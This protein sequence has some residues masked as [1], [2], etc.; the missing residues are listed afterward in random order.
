MIGD[1]IAHTRSPAI[2]NAAFAD[3]GLR[4]TYEAVRVT[5]DQLPGTI[6]RVRRG[7]FDGINVT[8]PHKRA[9]ADL[10]DV[11]T[12]EA[13]RSGSVNTVVRE[14]DGRLSGHSTDITAMRRLWRSGAIPAD[15][16][17]LVL[18][19]GGAASAACLAALGRT[20][21]VS[22]RRREAAEEVAAH[23]DLDICPLTWGVAVVEAILVNATTLGMKGE[24]LG[25][26]LVELAAGL[27]DLTYGP[28]PTPAVLKAKALGIPVIDGLEVLVAQAGDS[29]RLWTGREPPAEV[30][31]E[32]ARNLS[33]HPEGQP[34][35][36]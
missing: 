22:A 12:A 35:Q 14:A 36:T 30:M 10:V 1:P 21:Y 25:P 2:H 26:N 3:L 13:R 8:M 16:P 11:L 7:E 19:A 33:R 32:A 23:I 20:V 17:V 24:S 15:N 31:M 29:F 28:D 4:G 34:N 27:I 9:V 18:G 6:E 5:A